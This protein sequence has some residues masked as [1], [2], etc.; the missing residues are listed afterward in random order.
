MCTLLR[1]FKKEISLHI[2]TMTKNKEFWVVTLDN[3]NSILNN[4]NDININLKYS[5]VSINSMIWA[6]G[7]FFY[8]CYIGTLDCCRRDMDKN[9]LARRQ[10][11]KEGEGHMEG[12]L[13]GGGGDGEGGGVGEG[14][15][16]E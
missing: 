12:E 13:G 3:I 4:T 7:Y 14:G 16:G 10:G 15:S 2:I 9:T 5:K 1:N 8:C 11:G 6:P